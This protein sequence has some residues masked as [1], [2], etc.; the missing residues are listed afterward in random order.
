MQRFIKMNDLPGFC[1]EAA[2]INKAIH[3]LRFIACLP[4]QV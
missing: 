4:T 2:I 3:P 1:L